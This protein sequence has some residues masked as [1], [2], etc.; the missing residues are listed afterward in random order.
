MVYFMEDIRNEQIEALRVMVE[1]I[2]KLKKGMTTVAAELSGERLPDTDEYLVKV[3]EGLNWVIEVL[4][5]T[6]SLINEKETRLDKGKINE[7]AIAFSSAYKAKDDA[8]MALLLNTELTDFV[9][10]FEQTAQELI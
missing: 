9:N 10:S 2:P 4:N 7:S 8:E 3:I 5:G 1:Y 6:L